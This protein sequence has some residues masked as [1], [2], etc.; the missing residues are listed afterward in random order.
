M[1][2]HS[3]KLCLKVHFCKYFQY[4]HQLIYQLFSFYTYNFYN[5]NILQHRMIYHI[6]TRIPNKSLS[7]IPLSINCI[8]SH[9][10][11]SSFHL[12]CLLLQTLPSNL[13]L[14][15]QVLCHFMCLVSLVLD[16]RL[17]TILF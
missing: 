9:L 1:E 6:H 2:L 8:H 15:F 4:T 12:C 13:H 14:H 5:L 10:H 7:H 11:L 3:T 17:N 16:I